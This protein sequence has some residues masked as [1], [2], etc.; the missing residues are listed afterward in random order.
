MKRSLLTLALL[1][2]ASTLTLAAQTAYANDVTSR[3]AFVT[4]PAHGI[5]HHFAHKPTALTTWN[6]TITYNSHNYNFTMV[7]TNPASSNTTTTYNTFI[8]PVKMVY[9]KKIYGS[10]HL[11]LD[12]NKDQWNGATITASLVG[13]PLFNNVDWNWGGTDFGTTQYID[14]FQR[15]SFWGDGIST[16]NTNYHVLFGAPT[17]LTEQVIKVTKAQG[18]AV[19]ANPFGSGKVGEM[20]INSFD[21]FIQATLSKFSSQIN[22]TNIPIFLIENVYLTSGGCC[23]GGYHSADNNG[24]SY[25]MAT[26]VT[27][28]G[29]FSQDIS[30]FSHEMGEWYDDPLITSNSPCGLLEVGDPIEGLANYGDITVNYNGINWHPQAMAWMEYFGEP[31]NFSGNNWLDNNHDLT[32]VCQNGQ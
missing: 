9:T 8:I 17:V 19:I 1:A 28:P 12:P 2:T 11:K 27:S 3:P 15:G 22:P 20:N 23:I 16:T 24:Q 4:L 21:Q 29:A 13:S 5:I 30:A 14:G 26:F 10:N 7:G 25:M 32:R 6:G 31:A 18:G